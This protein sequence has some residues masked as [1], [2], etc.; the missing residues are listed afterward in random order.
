[1]LSEVDYTDDS[2]FKAY[3]NGDMQ[4]LTVESASTAALL[5]LGWVGVCVCVCVCVPACVDDA[6][7]IQRPPHLL[8]FILLLG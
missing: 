7:D 5:G 1:M 3:H 6:W 8:T 4:A 2:C